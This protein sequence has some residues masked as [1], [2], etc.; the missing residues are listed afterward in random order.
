MTDMKEMIAIKDGD[1]WA[2]VL[3]SF[4]NLQVS[5][6]FW[7]D[8][9]VS[10]M[11]NLVYNDLMEDEASGMTA[12]K[13]AIDEYKLAIMRVDKD[14]YKSPCGLPLKRLEEDADTKRTH[15]LELIKEVM[16]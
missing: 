9:G 7:T 11:L 16:K 2:F 13:R 1:S 8:A 5:P 4:E 10:L 15:L 14:A 6:S 3:P 12:I